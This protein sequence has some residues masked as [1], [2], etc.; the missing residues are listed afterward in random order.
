MAAAGW[1]TYLYLVRYRQWNRVTAL[2]VAALMAFSPGLVF[3]ATASL[4]S[5]CVFA[6]LLLLAFVT[7]EHCAQQRA[8]SRALVFAAIAAICCSLAFL[9]RSMALGVIL[10]A[11]LYFLK[12]KLFKPLV[13]FA[14]VTG[15]LLGGW[16][17]YTRARKPT[18]AQRAEVNN[19]IVRP[20]N[21]QFWDRL[22]G[23]ES[24]GSI[25][26]GELPERVLKNIGSVIGSD[27]GGILFP[28][29]FPSLNQ[30]LA[31]RGSAIQLI[32]SLLA[33]AL[34]VTGF[35]I[36]VRE[37]LTVAELAFPISLGIV[38]LW[39]FPPYR[40]LLPYL[41]LL[42][43]YFLTGFRLVG[44]AH[45]RLSESN[46][47]DGNWLPLN[48]AAGVM[49]LTALLG[50]AN[51]IGRQYEDFPQERPRMMRIFAEQEKVLQWAAENLPKND[52]I[53]TPNPALTFLYTGNRTTTFD[54]APGN[55]ENWN[56]LGVRYL[57]QLSPVRL[58]EP[59]G[60]EKQYRVM[61]RAGGELNLRVMDL[62]IPGSRPVWGE[63]GIN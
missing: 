39:P 47:E 48:V 3:M 55:W 38:I 17:L 57:L 26:L 14:L 20:Y 37:R 30:G 34:I 60:P 54:N 28:S 36:C 43:L 29:F 7:V 13:V 15:I 53:V 31:E 23:Y 6:A 35:V 59:N 22:A 63:A 61:H 51:Y 44:R 12:E 32:L 33:C 58:P 5:E 40:F 2:L 25:T 10:A 21:E 45:R 49:L 16:T 1:L 50:N 11:L 19:Y 62:G 24:Q 9:T 27:T 42:V 56:K 8:S 18:L 4:M 41:P 46:L 52:V